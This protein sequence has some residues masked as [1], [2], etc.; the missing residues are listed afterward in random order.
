MTDVDLTSPLMRASTTRHPGIVAYIL[1]LPA[2][3]ATINTVDLYAYTALSYASSNGY[4]PS[5]QLL[6]DAGADPT[7]PAGEQSRYS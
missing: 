7:I 3:R 4:Q 5:V 6:L 2:A 1:Q